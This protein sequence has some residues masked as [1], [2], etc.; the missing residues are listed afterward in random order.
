[1]CYQASPSNAVFESR[2]VDFPPSPSF[3]ISF[4]LLMQNPMIRSSLSAI[5]VHCSWYVS[6]ITFPRLLFLSTFV[7]TC[8][9]SVFMLFI[10]FEVY[11][12]GIGHGYPSLYLLLHR[13]YAASSISECSLSLDSSLYFCSELSVFSL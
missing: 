6:S 13:Y 10:L 11:R 2:G 5:M 4:F 1:M 12:K 7:T 9:V 8:L 3:E